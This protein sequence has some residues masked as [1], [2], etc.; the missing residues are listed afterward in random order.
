MPTKSGRTSV[1]LSADNEFR[2]RLRPPL[3]M[4]LC[5]DR[6]QAA[7][8]DTIKTSKQGREAYGRLAGY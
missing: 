4:P 7:A 3:F 8:F 5:K 1:F 6:E 2:G